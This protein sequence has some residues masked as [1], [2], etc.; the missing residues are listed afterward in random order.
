MSG[1]L[2]PNS[3]LMVRALSVRYG[4]GGSPLREVLARLVP[5]GLIKFEQNRGFWVAPLS[6][7]E[8][9]E[10]TEMRQLIEVDGFRRSMQKG[11]E[12]WEARV[13]LAHHK[14]KKFLQQRD[15]DTAESRREWEA[16][17]RAFHLALMDASGNRKL[18]DAAEQLYAQLARYRPILQINDLSTDELTEIHTRIFD[19]AM[20]R[21][22][23]RGAVE[24]ARHFEVNL[25]QVHATI[26]NTPEKFK[27]MLGRSDPIDINHWPDNRSMG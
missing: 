18:L 27:T 7:A 16:R 4:V 22:L 8:L 10:I 15:E 11:D 17:H 21:D 13:L 14:L 5:E 6:I 1:A 24:L 25:V 9:V 12:D 26:E 3:K 2:P 19:I 23:T 20:D